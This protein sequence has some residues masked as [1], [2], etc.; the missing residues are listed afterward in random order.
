M[1][2]SRF[3]DQSFELCPHRRR[4]IVAFERIG[5]IGRKKAY[6]R[7]AVEASAV[8]FQAIERLALGELDHRVVELDLPAGAALLGGKNVERCRAAGCSGR[9]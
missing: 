7:A 2:E 6:L 4:N 3:A 1:T 8:E 5:D 9:L